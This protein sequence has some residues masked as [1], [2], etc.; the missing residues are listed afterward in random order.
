MKRVKPAKQKFNP[1]QGSLGLI[2]SVPA[3]SEFGFT[4]NPGATYHPLPYKRSSEVQMTEHEEE[5][6]QFYLDVFR[7]RTDVYAKHSSSGPG[8]FPACAIAYVPGQC[9]KAENSE[10]KCKDC[11]LRVFAP[12]TTQVMHNHF[13]KK[14]NIGLYLLFPDSTCHT[15]AVDFDEAEWKRDVLEFLISCK[16][17]GIPAYTEVSR[18][19]NGAHVWFFFT[20]KIAAQIARKL[21]LAL[22]SHAQA[23]SGCLKFNSYDRLFPSQDFM[24]TKG[25]RLG[26]LIACPSQAECR[27]QG[28]SLFVDPDDDF[29]YYPRQLAFMRKFQRVSPTEVLNA[30]TS[31]V[32]E[33]QSELNVQFMLSNEDN[34]LWR[35]SPRTVGAISTPKHLE[36]VLN[37]GIEFQLSQMTPQFAMLLARLAA[38]RN[39]KFFMTQASGYSTYGIPITVHKAVINEKTLTLPRGCLDAAIELFKEYEVSYGIENRRSMGRAIDVS[40]NGVLREDQAEA[41]AA[42]IEFDVGT[43]KAQ[44]SFGKTVLGAALI[45]H[46][47]VSTLIVVP[48][49]NLVTQWS[50]RLCKFFGL[51]KGAV[52]HVSSKRSKQTGFIDIVTIQSLSRMKDIEAITADY[53]HVIIDEC[54]H[55]AAPTAQDNLNKIRTRYFTGL[56]ATPNRSD[57]QQPIVFMT[58]GNVRYVS[59]RPI[60]APEDLTVKTRTRRSLIPIPP[61]ATTNQLY[62]YLV[63]DRERTREIAEDALEAYERGRKV[64]LLTGRRDHTLALAEELKGKV[65]NLFV[66]NSYAKPKDREIVL[67]AM[68][69]L[70]LDT[71]RILISTWHLV[72]EG[73]DHAPLNTMILGLPFS[74]E[75]TTVQC[76]GRLDRFMPDKFDTEIID[77]IDEGHPS[78]IKKWKARKSAYK[79]I[80][81]RVIDPMATMELL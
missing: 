47:R 1:D 27:L 5:I 56:S 9:P 34:K 72:G 8:Y 76:A 32:P 31:L 50:K 17:F 33:G 12:L 68:E 30:I 54:Q 48:R 62:D 67:D 74:W 51:E 81:Y 25:P 43:L 3:P 7:P 15:A 10:F 64:V 18:S 46:R 28:F 59:K 78:G 29:K 38:F 55:A 49:K 73:F 63:Q 45:A 16:A 20:E 4:D 75:G 60:G 42:M 71:P 40:F 66:L 11:G 39:P 6:A 57:G 19:G 69:A 13:H 23:R 22:I 37:A 52:G 24:P 35:S 14:P 70:P 36:I 65:E 44:P 21:L 26:N 58:A 2:P 53:G 41:F 80:G 79:K 61:D 77:I